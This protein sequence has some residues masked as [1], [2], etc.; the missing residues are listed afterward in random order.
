MAK[1]RKGRDESPRSPR[2][3]VKLGAALGDAIAR[4]EDVA[5]AKR[6]K[7]ARKLQQMLRWRLRIR[8]RAEAQLWETIQQA[9]LSQP[10]NHWEGTQWAP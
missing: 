6:D 2:K 5:A 8:L 4:G 9:R 3:K 1:A 7:A 10:D